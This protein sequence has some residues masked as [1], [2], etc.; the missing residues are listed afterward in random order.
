MF[1]ASSILLRTSRNSPRQN[2]SWEIPKE[3]LKKV[4]KA[5]NISW[6]ILKEMLREI[7]RK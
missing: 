3:M 5:Q 6:E 7:P 1:A 4:R 2:I